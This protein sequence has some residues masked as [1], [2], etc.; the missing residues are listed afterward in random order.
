M[1]IDRCTSNT[2]WKGIYQGSLIIAT[3]ANGQGD[4]ADKPCKD[5]GQ[6]KCVRVRIIHMPQN[7]YRDTP[8]PLGG[9]ALWTG[10]PYVPWSDGYGHPESHHHQWGVQ[11]AWLS[12]PNY[13]WPFPSIPFTCEKSSQK[14]QM[15]HLRYGGTC[16]AIL[17]WSWPFTHPDLW[18]F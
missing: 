5:K 16:L 11:N 13:E 1:A 12:A 4:K 6:Q 7:K 8:R 14:T 17:L 9:T 15:P 10:G 18:R 3:A 2:S